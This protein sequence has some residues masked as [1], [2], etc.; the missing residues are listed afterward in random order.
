MSE[1]RLLS[2]TEG[3]ASELVQNVEDGQEK[4]LRGYATLE[5]TIKFL[6][7]CK[8]QIK[9][10]AITEAERHNEK[11][12]TEAGFEFQL[13]EGRRNWSFSNCDSWKQTNNK[14]KAI[15]RELK[16]AYEAMQSGERVVANNDTGEIEVPQLTFSKPSLSVKP[17]KR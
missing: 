14:L 16:G 4:P 15:E 6:T 13:K 12:F 8:N 10:A 17:L 1:N 3:V 7:E 2:M 9:D 11:T 5:S